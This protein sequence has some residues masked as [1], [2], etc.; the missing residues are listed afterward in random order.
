MNT[1]TTILSYNC[2]KTLNVKIYN[3]QTQTQFASETLNIVFERKK[4]PF[5]MMNR[6]HSCIKEEGIGNSISIIRI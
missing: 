6:V 5:S 1:V 2:I 4:G 3:N